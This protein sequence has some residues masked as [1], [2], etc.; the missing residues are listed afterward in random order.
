MT[1]T[2]QIEVTTQERLQQ[3]VQSIADTITS[4]E[5]DSYDEETG[6]DCKSNS[7]FDYLNDVLD[8]TYHVTSSK[9]YKAAEVL[10]AFGGP[11]IY[12]NTSTNTVEGYWWSDRAS[13]SFNDNLGLDEALEELYNC[14]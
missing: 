5:F 9:E 4:G 11:N 12:I 2:T 8:I 10:V 14:I 6:E 13:A 3:Q 7:G 1:Q